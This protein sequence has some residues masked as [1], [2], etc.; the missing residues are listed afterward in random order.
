[1]GANTFIL[2][3]TEDTSDREVVSEFLKQFYAEAAQVP[4]QVLLPNEVEEAQIIKQWLNTRRGGQKVELL[5]PHEGSNGRRP[6]A[7]GR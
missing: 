5:V 6:G 3:G 1:M 4:P 7:D 2:E